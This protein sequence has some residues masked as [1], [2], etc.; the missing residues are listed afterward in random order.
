MTRKVRLLCGLAAFALLAGACGGGDDVAEVSGDETSATQTAATDTGTASETTAPTKGGGSESE[1]ANAAITSVDDVEQATVQIVAEG[2]FRDPEV[3]DVQGVGAGSGFIIDPE[4]IAVTNNHVVTG[5]ASLNVFVAGEDEP[6][7]ARVLGVSE[8]SDLA[9]ID[10]D[11]DGYPYLE[12]Y[13]GEVD[14]R[15]DVYAAGFPLGDPAFTLT[16]GIVN[17][18]DRDVETEWASV[19][20]VIE[21]SARIRGGNSGGPLV[22]E[23]GQVVGVNY[24]GSDMT[25]QNLA[26]NVTEARDLVEQLR[27]GEDVTSIGVNGIAVTDGEEFAG[28][29]V[30]SVASGSPANNAG[31]RG[32][33]IITKLEN[34]GIGE[35]GT[36]SGYC[37]IL[38]SRGPED[39]LAV[40]VIRF[41]TEEVLAGQ[42][43]GDE[44]TQSFSFAQ[45]LEGEATTDTAAA[46][47]YS[48]FTTITDDTGAISVE[49]P[50]EWSQIDGA[51]YTD[52]E[53]RQIFDVRA[54]SNLEDFIGE[55]ATWNTPGMIF[56]ASSA[57]AQSANELTLLEEFR[58][59]EGQCTYAGR[60]PYEDAAYTG[61][62]DVYTDCGGVGATAVVVG[63]V[64]ADR[65]FV[66][67][68]FIQAN[69]DRDFEALDRI[70]NSFVVTGQV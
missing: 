31:L 63:A 46:D 41:D 30:S 19:E 21:H 5:S 56:S 1:P 27:E 58:T 52:D 20:N 8:C 24:A 42:I 57:L 54:S 25:D 3:G 16:D 6:R 11:G 55:N 32:G 15:L 45:E 66:I 70:L 26:I 61:Q 59:L 53:G 51:P 9:V 67:R 39:V 62:Y 13:D 14:T 22:T 47:T 64:P 2:A 34:V 17:T 44:L 10:I 33:D 65:S 35:D 28:V 60:Q 69:S 4:G 37:D 50:N 48:G 36:M 68:V 18:P 29:W 38:R 40:E 43:N 7:N 23:E 49:V 12:W